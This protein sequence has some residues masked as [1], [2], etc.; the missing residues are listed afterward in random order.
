MKKI[1]QMK[2][3]ELIEVALSNDID[4]DSSMNKDEIKNAI[5]DAG[6]TDDDLTGQDQSDSDK[7]APAE[8]EDEV[9]VRM[10]KSVAYYQY[11]SH[12]FT[13]NDPFAI[14]SKAEAEQLLESNSTSFK[15]ASEA[16]LRRFFK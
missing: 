11:G 16:D 12:V 13:K 2:K 3:D 14:M 6:V 15:K 10:M 1:A 8:T 4:V 5:D 9:I 7:N